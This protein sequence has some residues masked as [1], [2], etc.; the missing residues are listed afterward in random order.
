[1]EAVMQALPMGHAD[2][3]TERDP[4]YAEAVQIV[5]RKKRGSISLVQRH[6]RIG[7]NHAAMLME[8]MERAGVVSRMRQDGTRQVLSGAAAT[9]AKAAEG[10]HLDV[11]GAGGCAPPV[12]ASPV[13]AVSAIERDRWQAR[14]LRA[15]GKLAELARMLDEYRDKNRPMPT[16]AEIVQLLQ[17]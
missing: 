12:L 16:Y 15:E 14:A 4:M 6:L 17:G 11:I 8:A 7:Y 10:E 13:V 3:G 5:R 2:R 1:M 9:G